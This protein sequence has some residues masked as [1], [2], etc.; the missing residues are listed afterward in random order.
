MPKKTK[1][2][3]VIISISVICILILG[4]P[5]LYSADFKITYPA[6]NSTVR[7][8]VIEIEGTGAT[9][10][11]T[12]EVSVLTN[13]WYVQDGKAE[14]MR[15]GTWTYAPCYLSGKGRFN[16]HSIKAR[17]IKDGSP[18]TSATVGGIVRE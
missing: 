14:I 10:G 18:L 4:I 16:N 12:I 13:A 17:L 15:D 3:A 9:Q 8:E 7:G 1:V 11:A 6:P 2:I 5:F